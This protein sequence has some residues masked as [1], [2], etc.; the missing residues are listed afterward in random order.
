MMVNLYENAVKA[1]NY[2]GVNKIL[3]SPYFHEYK[4]TTRWFRNLNSNPWN[5]RSTI[6][7]M[8]L[9]GLKIKYKGT[10]LGF[11]WS[12]L[13]PLAQ[14]AVLYVVFSAIRGDNENFVVYLF[15]GLIIIHFFGRSTTQGMNS[16]LSNKPIIISL[17]VPRQIFPISFS[18]NGPRATTPIATQWCPRDQ[19]TRNSNPS[20]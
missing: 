15:I 10:V 1:K 7:Y 2:L 16:L 4:K 20:I 14:L 12:V 6:Y 18:R 3:T 11:L 19:T 9:A 17:N 5:F 8:S 13:E